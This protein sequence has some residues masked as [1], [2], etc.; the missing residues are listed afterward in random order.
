MLRVK[1]TGMTCNH[2]IRVIGVA[3]ASDL[4]QVIAG[5]A[6]AGYSVQRLAA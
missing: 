5:I 1:T 4:E 3:G 6:D 2:C